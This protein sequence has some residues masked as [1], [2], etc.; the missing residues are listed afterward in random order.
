M[1]ALTTSNDELRECKTLKAQPSSRPFPSPT[2]STMGMPQQDSGALIAQANQFNRPA[3]RSM[4]RPYAVDAS[5]SSMRIPMA[6]MGRPETPRAIQR[7]NGGIFD[8][9]SRPQMGM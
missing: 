2:R 3:I 8:R 1:Q 9:F 4:A 6:N 7:P 5:S